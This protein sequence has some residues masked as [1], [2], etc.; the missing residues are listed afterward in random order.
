MAERSTAAIARSD[1]LINVDGFEGSHRRPENGAAWPRAADG[2]DELDDTL[3]RSTINDSLQDAASRPRHRRERVSA[4][5]Q[6]AFGLYRALV[7]IALTLAAGCAPTIDEDARLAGI[8]TA[9]AASEANP[10]P[11]FTGSSFVAADGQVLPLR[12]WLPAKA[13]GGGAVKA[14]ILALHGFNDYS[15]AFEGSGE[16]WAKRGIATYAYDQRGFGAAPERG[17]WPGQTVLAADAVTASQILRRLYPGV[18][19]Y[20]LGDSMG[21]AVAVVA[22]TGESGIPVPDVDGIILIA[23]AVWGRSTMD[24]LPRLALWAGVRVAPGLTVTGRGLEIKPSDNIPMLRAL[25]R[26]PLVIKET[27]VDTIYGLVDLMDAALDSAPL[28]EAPLLVMY[29]AKD[30]IVPKTAIRHFVGDLPPECRHHAKL[31]WYKDGYH[32]LL[33]DLE[34]PVVASDVASWVLAPTAPLSSGADRTAEQAFSP[35]GSQLSVDAR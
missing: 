1:G 27:R 35:G 21:G 26:D 33:R 9:R 29:G 28:L 32:M 22:M 19:L 16:A 12:K 10:I 3:C 25:S 5:G 4:R 15:N 31:A 18:P 8:G 2:F 20:L 24:L 6:K 13:G 7:G 11:R 17:F 14:V 34:G 23:P 30:E